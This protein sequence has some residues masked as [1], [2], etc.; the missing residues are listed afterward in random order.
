M[1]A[2]LDLARPERKEWLRPIQGLDL[3][4]LIHTENQRVLG[5]VHIQAY[6]VAYLLDELRVWR[7]FEGIRPMGLQ[8]KG[9]PYPTDRHPAQSGGLGHPARAPM[10]LASRCAFQGLNHNFF[11]FRIA[12][13]P[14]RTRARFIVQSFQPAAQEARPPLAYHAQGA[15]QLLGYHLVIKSFG[16]GQHDPGAPCQKRLTARPMGQ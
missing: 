13:L 8:S 14:R 15:A 10:R 6:D 4:L 5:R 3:A 7:Q 2:A 1:R 11:Y 16:T 9:T 12:D